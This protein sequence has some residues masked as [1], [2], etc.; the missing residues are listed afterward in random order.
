M[1]SIFINFILHYLGDTKMALSV[2]KFEYN[3]NGENSGQEWKSW[4]QSF[5]YFISASG[6]QDE[7]QKLNLLLHFAGKSVQ[8]IY[9]Q[10]QETEYETRGPLVSGYILQQTVYEQ[11]INKLNEFFYHNNMLRMNDMF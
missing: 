1:F 6:V 8:D 7:Q 11:A 10:L 3:M 9:T 2:D 4:L 5:Q